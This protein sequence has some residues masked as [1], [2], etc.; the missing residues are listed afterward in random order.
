MLVHCENLLEYEDNH[1]QPKYIR[2]VTALEGAV[3]VEYK[4]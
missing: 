4:L 3:S 2:L 1:N